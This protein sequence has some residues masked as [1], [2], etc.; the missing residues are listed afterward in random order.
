MNEMVRSFVCCP[1]Q[2][3]PLPR[4]VS[5]FCANL[6]SGSLEYE[7]SNKYTHILQMTC[8]KIKIVLIDSD[9]YSTQ[10]GTHTVSLTVVIYALLLDGQHRKKKTTLSHIL[11]QLGNIRVT[12][13][14][15]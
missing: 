4:N 7:L 8:A 10:A 1:L 13:L 6:C 3:H 14:Q 15:L 9:G 12:K 5:S 2:G 11:K